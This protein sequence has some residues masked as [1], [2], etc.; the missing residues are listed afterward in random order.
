L[1][2]LVMQLIGIIKDTTLGYVVSYSELLES[3][4][5]LGSYSGAL[6]PAYIVVGAF[7]RGRGLPGPG[8]RARHALVRPSPDRRY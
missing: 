1:P 5:I 4:R 3:G 7:F 6:L 2:Q 8:R